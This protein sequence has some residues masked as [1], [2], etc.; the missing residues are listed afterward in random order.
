V[1]RA[2]TLGMLMLAALPARPPAV[3]ADKIV[4]D[5]FKSNGDE[6]TYYLFIPENPR[7]EPAPLIILLHGS[8]RD[9]RILV[10]HWKGL[11]EREG[12]VLAGPDAAVRDGWSMSDDGPV[13]LRHLVEGLKLKTAFDPRRV[14]IFGHSAGAIHGLTMAVLESEYFAAVAAHAGVLQPAYGSFAARAPRKTPIGIWVGTNDRL[15]PLEKVRATRDA[16]NEQ[17][18]NAELTEI[19]GHTHDYYSRSSQINKGVWEFLKDKRLDK[20]PQYQ[21]YVVGR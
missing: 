3:I 17:G 12:I 6:R 1:I 14:Y 8:G 7:K 15:F 16:L 21:D 19:S 9:G 13:L 2:L 4:K 11:A 20:D 5:T 10:E 18:F